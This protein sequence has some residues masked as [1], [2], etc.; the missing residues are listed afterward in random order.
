LES[1]GKLNLPIKH[2]IK[3]AKKG[4]YEKITFETEKSEKMN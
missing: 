1:L 3:K 2:G 4:F